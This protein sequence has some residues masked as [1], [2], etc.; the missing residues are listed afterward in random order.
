VVAYDAS[1]G[2]SA[3]RAWWLL[4]WAGLTDVRLLDG[5]LAAWRD[6]G[7][8]T[9]AGA[10]EPEPGDVVLT[11]GGLATIEADEAARWPGVLL[12]AR[13]GE[14]F[15]GETEPVDP[16]RPRSGAVSAPTADNLDGTGRFRSTD[17]LAAR[18][19]GLLD[20]GNGPV[21]V[22]CGSA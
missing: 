3:A 15:R 7:L 16:A 12:D 19:A 9:E 8:A 4:R 20:P 17:Q 10:V 5:G 6:A 21:A 22:Y 14:R 18:F 13:A 1:G 2:M 11:P